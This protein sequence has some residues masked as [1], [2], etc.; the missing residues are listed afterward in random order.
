MNLLSVKN[1]YND[2]TIHVHS[3]EKSLISNKALSII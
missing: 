2:K 1:F 3:S